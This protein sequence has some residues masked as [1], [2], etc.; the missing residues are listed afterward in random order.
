MELVHYLLI[1]VVILFVVLL[2]RNNTIKKLSLKNKNLENEYSALLVK[3]NEQINS[4]TKELKAYQDNRSICGDLQFD[5]NRKVFQI[6]NRSYLTSLPIF[7]DFAGNSDLEN[8]RL[9]KAS[10]SSMAIKNFNISANISSKLSNN[11]YQTTLSSCTCEDFKHRHIPCKHMYRLAL[12]IGLLLNESVDVNTYYEKRIHDIL[13]QISELETQNKSVQ[14]EIQEL[15][16]IKQK[17]KNETDS[18]NELKI[19]LNNIILESKQN[20][21]WLAAAFS[22]YFYLKD[23]E[24]ASYLKSKNNPAVKAADEVRKIASEKRKI[25]EQL[26]LTE[27]QL[28]FYENIFPWLLDFKEVSIEEAASYVANLNTYD[29]DYEYIRKWLSPEEYQSLS[30]V[31]KFQLALD[32]Y[33]NRKKSNWDVGIEY[34]RF[35]GYLYEQKGYNVKYNGAIMGLSDMGRDLIVTNNDEIIVIQCKRWSKEKEIHEKHIFQLYGTMVLYQIQ[36][37]DRKIKGAFYTSTKLSSLCSECAAYLG[38]EVFEN[39]NLEP[40][41]LVK[42]NIGRTGDK[43]Y[44]LPFD[45]QYDKVHIEKEKGEFFCNT[46]AEAEKAGF[47]RAFKWHPKN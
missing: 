33:Q 44:H 46:V 15:N 10:T 25:T 37:P 2:G 47:R 3:K 12:E 45:Q 34:E 20:F 27:Y 21:P 19:E 9:I 24:K 35:I 16:S 14:K 1:T 22:D 42:C 13:K 17:I 8:A 38:I 11:V 32:R 7:K 31:D 23:I 18:L 40:Y 30:T 43:I 39:F 41:P 26:K 28:N 4:L 29:S 6:R 5:I 36:H